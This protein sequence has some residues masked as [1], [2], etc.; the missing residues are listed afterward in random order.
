MIDIKT[1]T[2]NIGSVINNY[3][4]NI[5]TLI[6]G[7]DIDTNDELLKN[8]NFFKVGN[9]DDSNFKG[10]FKDNSFWGN[11][12]EDFIIM[13]KSFEIIFINIDNNEIKEINK[14]KKLLDRISIIL[15]NLINDGIIIYPESLNLNFK[16]IQLIN[17]NK[18]INNYNL[19]S[20]NKILNKK[21]CDWIHFT[22]NNHT[23]IG[24]INYFKNK[25]N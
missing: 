23:E 8:I 4:N 14:N 22:E 19:Y 3:N 24:I 20:T 5:S 17:F 21:D 7:I 25:Y 9:Y 12:F 6:I 13:D 1:I 2:R 10:D 11:L 18:N 16:N 15:Y